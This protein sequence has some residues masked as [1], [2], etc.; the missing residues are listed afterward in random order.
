MDPLPHALTATRF[1][2]KAW[3]R[4]SRRTPGCRFIEPNPNGVPQYQHNVFAGLTKKSH[5]WK[6]HGGSFRRPLWNPVG[7]H[8][9]IL[10]N[11]GCAAFA[12]TPG[13]VVQPVPGKHSARIAIAVA[14]RYAVQQ[15]KFQSPRYDGSQQGSFAGCYLN[16]SSTPLRL[17]MF[18]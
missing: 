10:H 16:R 12:S 14:T 15:H 3:G 17:T 13:F 2:N 18:L 6:H 9:V 1:H 4:R 11:L 7:V 5:G 8:N